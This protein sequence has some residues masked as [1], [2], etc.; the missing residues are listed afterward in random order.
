MKCEQYYIFYYKLKSNLIN[1]DPCCVK[2][3]VYYL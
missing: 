2:N 3:G 1:R